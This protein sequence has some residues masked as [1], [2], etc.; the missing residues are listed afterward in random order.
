MF[1]LYKREDDTFFNDCLDNDLKKSNVRSIV[2]NFFV[3]KV[4]IGLRI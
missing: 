4:C 2:N 1:N 3:I